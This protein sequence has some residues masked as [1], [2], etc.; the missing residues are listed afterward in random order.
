MSLMTIDLGVK[1]CAQ[2]NPEAGDDD[3]AFVRQMASSGPS[4]GQKPQSTCR[5]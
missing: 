4:A 3:L 5:W 2:I 1:I